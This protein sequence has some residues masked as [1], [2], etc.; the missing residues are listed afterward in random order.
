M[1]IGFQ[2]EKCFQEREREIRSENQQQVAKSLMY[3]DLIM[4][5]S[6]AIGEASRNVTNS[7][8]N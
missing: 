7:S 1:K 5:R 6:A 2:F 8:Y 4:Q 3:S